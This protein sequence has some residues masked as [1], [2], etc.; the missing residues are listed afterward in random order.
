MRETGTVVVGCDRSWE[1]QNAVVA[2]TRE[3]SRRNT[4]LVLLAVV[5]RRSFW[6]DSVKSMSRGEAESTQDAQAAVHLARAKAIATD[7]AVGV[8]TL[9][10]RELDSP[11]LVDL[12][13]QAGLLVLGHRGDGGQVVFSLGSTSAE[14][15]KRFHCPMLVVHDQGGPIASPDFVPDRAVVAGMDMTE[16]ADAVLSVAVTEAVIRDLP[17]VVV[18]ALPR[19]KSVDRTLISDC[20]RRVRA[21][22]GNANPPADV[23]CR[24][25]ITQD[26]P[27]QALLRR[28]GPADV[29][30]VGTR[31]QGRLEGLIP[32]SVSR[33]ILDTATCAV[34]V[35]Q[36]GLVAAGQVPTESLGF[37]SR[38]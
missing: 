35:V 8:E 5:E 34:M 6:P 12:A 27:I 28:V 33:A 18:H 21:T 32:G 16:G 29:L 9:I 15:S 2:A 20:W 24:L 37:A 7:P 38:L 10:V 17:L 26:D 3:A 14:L 30:V 4:R 13:C 19:A 36:P 31:G 11:E 1:S 25:A 23:P 22:L